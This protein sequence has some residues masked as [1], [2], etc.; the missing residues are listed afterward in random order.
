MITE[1]ESQKQ[2]PVSP[3]EESPPKTPKKPPKPPFPKLSRTVSNQQDN[4]TESTVQGKDELN[5]IENYVLTRKADNTTE[6]QP[7][8]PARSRSDSCKQ[9]PIKPPPPKA[10]SPRNSL[11]KPFRPPVPKSSSLKSKTGPPTT[12]TKDSL[13]QPPAKPPVPKSPSIK[14]KTTPAASLV[15]KESTSQSSFRPPIPRSPSK[16]LKI[17]T[18]IAT[19]KTSDMESTSQPSSPLPQ[20]KPRPIPRPR[21]SRNRPVP[22]PRRPTIKSDPQ[23]NQA[24]EQAKAASDKIESSTSTETETIDLSLSQQLDKKNEDEENKILSTVNTLNIINNGSYK[25]PDEEIPSSSPEN[26]HKTSITQNSR[27]PK[28]SYENFRVQSPTKQGIKH[29]Y[30]NVAIEAKTSRNIAGED[31]ENIYSAPQN[32]NC[33]EDE[34]ESMYFAPTSK[35]INIVVKDHCTRE[36]LYDV[37]PASLSPV[38]KGAKPLVNASRNFPAAP[39][40]TEEEIIY[41]APISPHTVDSHDTR[42]DKDSIINLQMN[43][44]RTITKNKKQL[45]HNASFSGIAKQPELINPLAPV[46]PYSMLRDNTKAKQQDDPVVYSNFEEEVLYSAPPSSPFKVQDNKPRTFRQLSSTPSNSSFSSSS[47]VRDSG[48]SR[49]SSNFEN[50]VFTQEE[51]TYNVPSTMLRS[52]EH[53]TNTLQQEESEYSE[54]PDNGAMERSD[55]S[56]SRYY[57]DMAGGTSTSAT[58]QPP[59]KPPR[60]SSVV[61]RSGSESIAPLP[62]SPTKKGTSFEKVFSFFLCLMKIL[63]ILSDRELFF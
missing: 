57:V 4:A 13:N 28:T 30:E 21:A 54:L 61:K 1:R 7:I 52:P 17:S 46:I 59:T 48:S 34:D 3:P 49:G 16:K 6:N 47:S 58:S 44:N 39:S 9:P 24:I 14:S 8:S 40:A 38:K 53:I 62:S 33:K 63:S 25:N 10:Q 5:N 29:T 18:P 42:F 55:S 45:A 27:S 19:T 15:N 32:I 20:A 50:S 36:D 41:A 2:L 23:D 31:N 43:G 51:D 26:S 35:P 11:Q 12:T 56:G 60:P 22:S 37:P